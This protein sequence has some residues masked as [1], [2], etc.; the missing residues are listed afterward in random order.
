M[1]LVEVSQGQ[2]RHVHYRDSKLTFLLRDSLGG[3]AKTTIIATVSPAEKWFG[4]TLSTLKFAQRAKHIKNKAVV[5]EETD[6]TVAML[7]LEISNLRKQLLLSAKTNG[8]NEKILQLEEENASFRDGQS[9]I[10]DFFTAVELTLEGRQTGFDDSKGE[11]RTT[12]EKIN[13]YTANKNNQIQRL[14]QKIRSLQND[15]ASSQLAC[16]FNEAQFIQMKETLEIRQSD[17]DIQESE[18]REL[19]VINFSTVVAVGIV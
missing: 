18:L 15:L 12:L 17:F 4:E 7:K 10:L 1:A 2:K 3:S 11:H 6:G 13:Q 16:D 5:N 9:N 19:K 14:E 8:D